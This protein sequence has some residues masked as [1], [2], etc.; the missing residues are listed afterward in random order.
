[1]IVLVS[2]MTETVDTYVNDTSLP[3]A[4]HQMEV[5]LKSELQKRFKDIEETEIVAQASILDPRFKKYDFTDENTNRNIRLPSTPSNNL[6]QT[7][8]T[9]TSQPSVFLL[10]KIYEDK[11]EQFK[12]TV[13]STAAGIIELGKYLRETLIYRKDV[14]L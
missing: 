7:P 8:T 3:R 1:M 2:S 10:W 4:V 12:S 11:V 9:S 13:L 5:S 14:P 6:E